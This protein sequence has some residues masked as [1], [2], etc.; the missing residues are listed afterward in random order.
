LAQ[1]VGF[2][3]LLS[4]QVLEH[5][6]ADGVMRVALN[7]SQCELEVPLVAAQVG[8]TIQIAVRAGDIMLATQL[9][10]GL[11]ARNVV[12]GTIRSIET[13]GTTVTLDVN[14]G[15]HFTVHVTPGALRS[16][17]LAPGSVVWLVLKTHSCHVVALQG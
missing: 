8:E 7:G 13:R 1:A 12:P 4:A 10:Y 11:S 5:R 3:N 16:L 9:P 14:A 2:E 6:P 15:V 17:E